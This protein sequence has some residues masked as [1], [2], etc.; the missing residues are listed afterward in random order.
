MRSFAGD[1]L[2]SESA[3]STTADSFFRSPEFLE[4]DILL[5]SEELPTATALLDVFV[6]P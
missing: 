1:S 3:G 2:S 5:V 6:Y 4:R